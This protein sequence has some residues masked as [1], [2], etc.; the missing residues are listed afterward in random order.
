M[1]CCDGLSEKMMTLVC[2]Y[3]YTRDTKAHE[4]AH[5]ALILLALIHQEFIR[6]PSAKFALRHHN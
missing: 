3:E 5:N 1:P 4:G 2:F 6:N